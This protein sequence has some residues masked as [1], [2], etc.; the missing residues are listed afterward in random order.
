MLYPY[1]S[2][3]MPQL[4]FISVDFLTIEQEFAKTFITKEE[5]DTNDVKEDSYDEEEEE[6]AIAIIA[7]I[8][9]I[10]TA[11]Y[12]LQLISHEWLRSIIQE[13]Q[14]LWGINLK[15]NE[16][17]DENFKDLPNFFE[18]KFRD[19]FIISFQSSNDGHDSMT[20][21]K[22]PDREKFYST[23]IDDDKD[24][25]VLR[26]LLEFLIEEIAGGDSG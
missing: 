4:Q 15:I 11:Q 22:I 3:N 5:K 21:W 14:D 24:E 19:S 2:V 18:F 7:E 17:V 26:F 25:E 20:Y 10:P 12:A 13:N 9:G 23:F 6:E 1:L 16:K 8:T